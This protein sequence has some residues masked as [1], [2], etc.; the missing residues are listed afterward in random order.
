VAAGVAAAS[1]NTINT[2]DGTLRQK[3]T[4]LERSELPIRIELG[5]SSY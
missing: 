1:E 2:K 5:K 4:N 3:Q